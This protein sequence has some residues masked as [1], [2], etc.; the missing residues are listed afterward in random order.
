M[1]SAREYLKSA[2]DGGRLVPGRERKS[3]PTDPDYL[4]EQVMQTDRHSSARRSEA[5]SPRNG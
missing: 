5:F 3:G 4:R 2:T 1:I